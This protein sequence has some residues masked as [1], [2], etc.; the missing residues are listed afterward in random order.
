MSFVLPS[1]SAAYARV[2]IETGVH[3]ADAHRLILMLFDG[4]L[5]AIGQA[6]AAMK[7]G[8]VALKG[9]F[10]SKAIQIVE[11]GLK[12]SLD[13]RAGGKAGAELADKLRALYDYITQRMLFASMRMQ[14]AGLEEASRLLRQLRDAWEQIR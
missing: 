10:V 6:S 2:G 7:A 4:A 12:A 13:D 14:P 3:S 8:N 5:V 9:E 11:E 1:S